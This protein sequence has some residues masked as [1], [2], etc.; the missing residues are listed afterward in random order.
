MFWVPVLRIRVIVIRIRIQDLK[1]FLTD[2]DP[3]PGWTLIQIQAELWYG[4]GSRKSIR[5]RRIWI[6]NTGSDETSLHGSI[7][8]KTC[9]CANV[10]ILYCTDTVESVRIS[11]LFLSKCCLPTAL[12]SM[13]CVVVHFF[14]YWNSRHQKQV[15]FCKEIF[16][17]GV[18]VIISISYYFFM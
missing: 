3:D 5:I 12:P 16:I 2:P 4:S 17:Y 8:R 10:H 9:F 11:K 6:S 18:I 1:N 13:H 7:L 15:W 14:K